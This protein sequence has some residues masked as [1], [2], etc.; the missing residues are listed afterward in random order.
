MLGIAPCIGDKWCRI[1][2]ECYA[3]ADVGG[4]GGE[5]LV[6]VGMLVR[7]DGAGN[8]DENRMVW[9]RWGVG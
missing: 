5:E 7:G 1:D 6:V 3:R 2:S 8:P 9:G 4:G